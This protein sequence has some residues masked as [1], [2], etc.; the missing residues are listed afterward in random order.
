MKFTL[1]K[2]LLKL[3]IVL[4]LSLLQDLGL[5]LG[6]VS[7]RLRTCGSVVD[8]HLVPV[9][10]EILRYRNVMQVHML[11]QAREILG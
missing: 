10:F 9:K 8:F 2:S 11:G 4:G 6:A 7:S 1:G 3:D 5:P